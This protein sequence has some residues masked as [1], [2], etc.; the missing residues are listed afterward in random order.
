MK[1]AQSS[2]F[3]YRIIGIV[4]LIVS[5]F[6]IYNFKFVDLWFTNF[7]AWFLGP[8]RPVSKAGG[9][10]IQNASILINLSIVLTSLILL[11]LVELKAILE[12]L[13][14]TEKVFQFFMTDELCSKRQLPVILFVISAMVGIFYNVFQLTF[15]Q[16]AKEGF[17]EDYATLLYVF[18]C[19]VL[20]AS[21]FTLKRSFFPLRVRYKIIFS[22]FVLMAVL[23]FLFGEEVSWGQRVIGYESFGVFE[24]Y[25]YQDEVNLHNFFNP[26]F[27]YLYP[28]AGMSLF[29]GLLFNWLF[30][31]KD[32]PHLFYLFVPHQSLFFLVFFMA[33]STYNGHSEIFEEMVSVLSLLYS[34]RVFFCLTY[35]IARV[36]EKLG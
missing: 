1:N 35:P 29:V 32:K 33:A 17:M 25:N 10:A 7:Y 9:L 14:D 26:L 23:T 19:F 4:G 2:N 36:P 22:L 13:I 3:K 24:K 31:K 8:E 16:P 12:R 27:K 15:G 34:I 18:A 30:D 21:V 20:L 5:F 11:F 28:L 6:L